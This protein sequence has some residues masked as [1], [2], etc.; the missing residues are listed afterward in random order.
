MEHKISD[1][2]QPPKPKKKFTTKPITS[3]LKIS[4]S[5]VNLFQRH[6]QVVALLL[7]R[8]KFLVAHKALYHLILW[9]FSIN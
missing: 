5:Q 1:A 4:S 3:P 9:I 7:D 2:L 6:Q 8:D